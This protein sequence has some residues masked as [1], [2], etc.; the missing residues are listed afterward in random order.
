MTHCP[1]CGREI[2]EAAARVETGQTAHG[3]A[4]VDPSKG[5]RSFHD[6]TWY[7][8]DTLACRSKFMVNP[9]TFLKQAEA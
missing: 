3:A 1:V 5:T 6:G 4:E 2:D 9:L 7:Y 8:F